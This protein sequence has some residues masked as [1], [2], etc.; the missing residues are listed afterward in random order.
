MIID[1]TEL[2]KHFPFFAKMND[3]AKKQFVQHLG[4]FLVAELGLVPTNSNSK[5]ADD[6]PA[7]REGT[8]KF[9]VYKIVK[10]EPDR[11]W[12]PREIRD[13]LQPELK[14]MKLKTTETKA[15]VDAAYALAKVGWLKRTLE[16]YSFI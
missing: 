9:M 16:G 10:A 5:P 8:L 6:R 14:K 15:V 4:E 3:Q 7:L 11:L 1:S 13:R 2:A 12:K